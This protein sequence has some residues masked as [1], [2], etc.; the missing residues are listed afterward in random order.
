MGFDGTQTLIK[1]AQTTV[2]NSRRRFNNNINNKLYI[3]IIFFSAPGFHEA[4]EFVFI[5]ASQFD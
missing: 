1:Q 5:L 3:Y 4:Q 2:I